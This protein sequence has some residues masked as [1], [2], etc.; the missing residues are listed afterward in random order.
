[1]PTA[2]GAVLVMAGAWFTETANVWETVLPSKSV[3]DTVTLLCP[4]A[5]PVSFTLVPL[6]VAVTAVG[7]VLPVTL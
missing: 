2:L 6:M 1:M 4:P 7:L 3:A 5:L